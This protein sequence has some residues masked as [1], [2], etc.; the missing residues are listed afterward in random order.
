MASGFLHGAEVQNVT[1]ASQSA[2]TI[3]TSVIG[4]VGTAPYADA[5]QWPLNTPVLVSGDDVSLI[6]A[7]SVNAP[8]NQGDVGTLVPAFSDILDE[9]APVVVAV[10]VEAVASSGSQAVSS[11]DIATIPNVVGGLSAAG[12]YTGVHALLAAES[13][14]GKRPRLLCAPG[15]THQTQTNGIIA[16]SVTN[17][18]SGYT[19]G[20]YPLTITD[21][22]G[23]S[24]AATVTVGSSGS[25]SLVTVTANGSGYSSSPSFAMP[26]AAGSGASAAFSATVAT[27]ENAVV[28][29]LKGIA[30]Q[31]GAVIYADGPNT[32]ATDAIT[33]AAEGGA[34]VMLIDPWFIKENNAGVNTSFPP[35]AKFAAKQAYVDSSVGFWASV[36]NKPLNGLLGLTRPIDFVLGSQTCQANVLN[37][38]NVTT[39]VRTPK[40]YTTWGNRALDGSFLCVTRTVD[41]INASVM[42]AVLQFVDEGITTNFVTE[43]VQY[44]NAY[45][46]KLTALG[47]ITGGKCWADTALNTAASV[48]SGQVY[49]DFDIGPVYPAER[50]TF[51]SSIND[52]YISTIFTSGA[53]S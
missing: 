26:A 6:A 10:R 52:G 11:Y 19:A 2:A 48:M 13:A 40:G 38:S 30:E 18:G 31:L 46:R 32:N 33:A 50:I 24:A 47:A 42:S 45:L 36:S 3:D 7:L 5:T 23:K 51:R 53:S 44:V 1:S 37:S 28:A 49:F 17:G 34:R 15:W 16:I 43:V 20:E 9:C 22:S 8:A 29:E 39:I 27:A 41:V 21:T 35:S 25:V 4:I 14:V 12:A